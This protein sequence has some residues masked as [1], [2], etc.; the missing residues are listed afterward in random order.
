MSFRQAISIY[1]INNALLA[2]MLK[3]RSPDADWERCAADLKSEQLAWREIA[4]C[5]QA[6]FFRSC[7]IL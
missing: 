6:T 1:G 7:L 4:G 3:F 5:Y 2:G